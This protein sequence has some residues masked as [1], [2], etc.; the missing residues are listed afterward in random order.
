MENLNLNFI[1]FIKN[2]E[3]FYKNK[4]LFY[5]NHFFNIVNFNNFIYLNLIKYIEF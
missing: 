2:L 5:S 1:F 4:I 3:I